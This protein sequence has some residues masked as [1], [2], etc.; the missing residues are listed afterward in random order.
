MTSAPETAPLVSVDPVL[1][2]AAGAR[3]SVRASVTNAATSPRVLTVVVLGL[4]P[5]WVGGPVTT[6]VLGPGESQLVEIAVVPPVGTFPAQY[7]FAVTV[8]A[9]DPET[10]RVAETAPGVA[11]CRLVVN[12]RAQLV[13]DLNPRELVA[14]HGG[15]LTVTLRNTGT[16][17]VPVDLSTTTSRGVHVRLRRDHVEVA[18]GEVVKVRGRVSANRRNRVGATT[19]HSFAVTAQGPAVV[20]RLDG[21]LTQRALVGPATLKVLSLVL[22]LGVWLTAAVVFIPKL[23]DSVRPDR[24]QTSTVAGTGDEGGGGDD[25]GSGSGAG[26][27][28]A[29][30]AG[31]GSGADGAGED[32][33]AAAGGG[34]GAQPAVARATP[35][36]Q[37]TGTVQAA[38]PGGVTVSLEP[39]SLVDEEAQGAQA[40]G[41]DTVALAATGMS[42]SQAFALTVPRATPTTRSASTTDDGSWSFPSISA[43]G[44]YLLTF[45]KPGYQTQKF[46][47]DS[48][49]EKAAEPLTVDLQPGEGSLRGRVT[50]P[51]GAIGGATITLTDGTS[52]ITTSTVTK[53]AATGSWSVEGLSTPATYVVTAAREGLSTESAQVDLAAGGG[54]DR[55]LTL[56]KGVGTLSGKV[57]GTR[58]NGSSGGLGG[59][60]VT[61]TDGADLV[62][63]TTTLTGATIGRYTVP[64]LPVPGTYTVTVGG[65]GYQTQV[66][67]VTFARGDGGEQLDVNP[68]TASTGVVTGHV[69]SREGKDLVGAGQVLS[70]DDETYKTTTTSADPGAYR[71]SGVTP[72]TYT[73]TTQ[74][75]GYVTDSVTVEVTAGGTVTEDRTLAVQPG[76]VLPST[77]RIT[78]R[79]LDFETSDVLDTCENDADTC[80]RATVEATAVQADGTEKPVTYTTSFARGEQ[81]TL[82]SAGSGVG[83]LPGVHQVL[84]T[85]PH[86]LPG[87]VDVQAPQAVTVTAEPVRLRRAPKVSGTVGTVVSSQPSGTTCVYVVPGSDQSTT[88]PTRGDCSTAY[89]A[90]QCQRTTAP[91]DGSPVA[92]ATTKCVSVSGAGAGPGSY[93][94]ELPVAGTYTVYVVPTDPAF[95]PT[96]GRQVVVAAG[97]S[98]DY[99]PVVDRYGTLT[100]TVMAPGPDNQ[101][102]VATT[103][104]VRLDGGAVQATTAGTRVFEPLDAASYTVQAYDTPDGVGADRTGSRTV[105]V[106]LNS[107]ITVLVPMINK[108]QTVVGQVTRVVDSVEGPVV[109]ATVSVVAPQDY[110][111]VYPRNGQVAP[112][113]NGAGCFA[114]LPDAVEPVGI[115]PCSGTDVPRTTDGSAKT[116]AFVSRTAT[117]ITISKPGYD[118]LTLSNKQLSTTALN[119]FR[120][121][122]SPVTLGLSATT[123]PATGVDWRTATVNVS[124]TDGSP[125]S[126]ALRNTSG[127]SSTNGTFVW[128]DPRY[129]DG[130]VRPGSYT[131]TVAL[132]GHDTLTRTMTCGVGAS[133]SFGSPMTLQRHGSIRVAV[134]DRSGAAVPLTGAEVTLD[135]SGGGVGATS[136]TLPTGAGNTVIF[137]DLSPDDAVSYTLTVRAP[138]AA[139]VDTTVT[140]TTYTLAC[141]TTTTAGKVDVQPGTQSSCTISTDRLGTITGEVRGIVAAAP[142]TTPYR[143]LGQ[144]QLT[145]TRCTATSPAGGTTWCTALSTT[146]VFTVTT[147]V[148]GRFTVTGTL[149]RAGLAQGTWLLT[150][151]ATGF[152]AEPV[153]S[154]APAGALPGTVV[155]LSAGATVDT[156]VAVRATPVRFTVHLQDSAR[157]AVEGASVV[158]RQ[159][160]LSDLTAVESTT[161]PGDYVVSQ[162]VP[163]SYTVIASGS[164]LI[165]STLYVGVPEGT[166]AS[167]YMP[168]GRGAN[169]LSGVITGGTPGGPVEGAV[170]EL[171]CG[172][173]TPYGA[174]RCPAGKPAVG[175][176]GQPMTFTT[177]GNGRY[178][179]RN[180][181]DGP[182]R[183][184]VT[185]HRFRASTPVDLTFDHDLG[186]VPAQDVTLTGVT[187]N[188]TITVTTSRTDDPLGSATL[189]LRQ[190]SAAP[191]STT[192]TGSGGT[193]TGLFSQLGSGCW[194][195]TLVLPDG[196][197][198]AVSGLTQP[199]A[200]LDTKLSCP[201]GTLQVSGADTAA[202]ATG[203][204]GVD[205]AKVTLSSTATALTGHTAPG[206]VA[207]SVRRQGTATPLWSQDASPGTSPA[208][209]LAPGTY[210]A[211][212]APPSTG[213]TPAFWP[214]VETTFTV[215]RTDAATP[216]VA[217]VEVTRD[218]LVT[219]SGLPAG[220]EATITV[221]AGG[222]QTATVTG[223]RTTSAGKVTL[224]L[225]E[226]AWTISAT[227]AGGTIADAAY[228]MTAT[229]GGIALTYVADPPPPP[230]PT[231][232]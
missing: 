2:T 74:L 41:V 157:A 191:L 216:T 212:I 102:A 228:T 61:V 50:G 225:P 91:Y 186:A 178:E 78:G 46:V 92:A 219:V 189:Q 194:T 87:T 108:I 54:A 227:S 62:R 203:A 30:D 199:A 150:S 113:T 99:D 185:A 116:A 144:T 180:V 75:F 76:G 101:L 135:I 81:Y 20:R 210:V 109:G 175:T 19:R 171:T 42:P 1:R 138:G 232:P 22:V 192:L 86:Y 34:T 8:Q 152:A 179:F 103:S 141:S 88:A 105:Y 231:T 6:G 90:G 111:D 94:V 211:R 107:D 71:F 68:L 106:G 173:G 23:A 31:G 205:E 177:A 35:Q 126:A 24:E 49:S 69:T 163:G 55:D 142:N 169:T 181:P 196:H 67:T 59:I 110:V 136:R 131:V 38:D 118:T 156:T 29:G 7:P 18:P 97:D 149:A 215:S 148:D 77:S 146:D 56:R 155:P 10:Q 184:S 95:K 112:T 139:S 137:A 183:L 104:G 16:D 96:S 5:G 3:C 40:V 197:T 17:P 198:G 72:G 195:A 222:G 14:R 65:T 45:A 123:A 127:T 226:G 122:P 57:S 115:A 230:A 162:V 193:F 33:G 223:S 130:R 73:L 200:Q 58:A 165:T 43:P 51:G 147:G 64:D 134:V 167:V 70:N 13:V 32:G 128:A 204:V 60:D 84:V 159:A 36:L 213:F 82:P 188:A 27:G 48:S 202:D 15:S 160:G 39:T 166:S 25:G 44:Y 80:L 182:Y 124:A 133:C 145:A 209:W 153:P 9:V 28:D 201:A 121:E 26:G 164:G 132:P 143:M 168:I 21:T 120:L 129:P 114:V 83:L 176:N 100:V 190:G 229:S 53:G 214:P 220:Q 187:R 117:S 47:V 217:L 125:V 221:T 224:A 79:A 151:G 89:D 207:L 172:S 140:S 218:A 12:P 161:T 4:E 52:T 98:V 93:S 206:T 11:Q 66:S 37:L 158:L 208:L 119:G 63:Q 85:A 170:V 174:S 154:G